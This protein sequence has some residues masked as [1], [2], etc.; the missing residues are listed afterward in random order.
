MNASN[1]KEIARRLDAVE[2]CLP[3]LGQELLR[4]QAGDLGIIRKSSD[5]DLLTVAD[6]A[7]ERRL[8]ELIGKA[9]PEDLILAEE[10]SGFATSAS[11]EDRYLWVLDPIDGTTNFANRLP[12]WA[13]SVGLMHRARMVGGL[14]MA[15]VLD[16]LYRAVLGLGATCNGQ[17]IRVNDFD[18]IGAGVVATGFPYDRAKRAAP[19]CCALENFL[20]AAGGLRR[21]GAASLDF[22]FV[23]DGRFIGYYEMG[24]KP[25]DFAAGSL[26][27]AEA[28]ATVTD[29]EGQPLDIFQSK[30]TVTSNGRIHDAMLKAAGPMIEAAAL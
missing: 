7:C 22:C 25:W 30:G 21:L 13:I 26:I 2:A 28:G 3:E 11:E 23:A 9:F 14:V 1:H 15:P 18:R 29:L 19:I 17:P 4:M 20:V 6:T 5:F 27:A 10:G 12:C 16:L 24:L 8:V